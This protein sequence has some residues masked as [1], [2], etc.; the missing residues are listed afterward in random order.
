MGIKADSYR[1]SD[2]DMNDIM[3]LARIVANELK[4]IRIP[5]FSVK[6]DAGLFTGWKLMVRKRNISSS[7][8][9]E[10]TFEG[11]TENSHRYCTYFLCT[12]GD[13]CYS[14]EKQKHRVEFNPAAEEFDEPLSTTV[15]LMSEEDVMR[16]DAPPVIYD[17][18]LP[19][20]YY[21]DFGIDFDN[22]YYEQK[23]LGLTLLLQKMKRMKRFD[24][25]SVD[26]DDYE[27]GAK[28]MEI[29]NVGGNNY[30]TMGSG[31]N[32][33]V[34]NNA[35]DYSGLYAVL[36]EM[37]AYAELLPGEEGQDLNDCIEVIEAEVPSDKPKKGLLRKAFDGV[38]KVAG[39][40]RFQGLVKTLTPIVTAALNKG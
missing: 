38:V 24:P 13:L 8:I 10:R 31:S 3:T 6:T 29:N 9:D 5:N 11:Y 27:D 14:E 2:F 35:A 23:G 19:N 4:S 37:R 30:G 25:L 1:A 21:D 39:D 15:Y 36:S 16:F 34:F 7:S 33:M 20:I 40:E 26:P 22:P 28:K 12:D 32:N 17:T 18:G